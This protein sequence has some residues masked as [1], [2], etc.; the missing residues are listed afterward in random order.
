LRTD[1]HSS[2]GGHVAYVATIG[3]LVALLLPAVQAARAAARRN[4]S[5][6]NMKQIMLGLLNYEATQQR[7]PAHASYDADGKPL[8][9]W[10]V[11]ILPF[12]EKQDLYNQFHLDEPWDSPHNITL[13]PLMP[14]IYL[15]PNSQLPA[16]AGKTH[17]LGSKGEGQ[18][19]EGTAEGRPVRTITDGTSN[20]I[21]V[22]QVNDDRTVPWTSPD[23][24]EWE[25]QSPLAGFGDLHPG[26]IF[27]G[28]WVDGSVQVISKNIDAGA[29]EALT[30]VAGGET[31]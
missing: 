26:G 20:T 13:I 15:D 3:V 5:M 24:W 29:F 6:N 16:A 19:F 18:F 2:E 1:F 25:E 27:L 14:E 22:V 4:A 21:A 30:T 23:D 9:S 8:L 12:L 28:G 17:Y 11:H 10:R 7:F 31:Q